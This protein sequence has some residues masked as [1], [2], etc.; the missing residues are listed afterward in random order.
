MGS[1]A[2]SA[3]SLD[4]GRGRD[5]ADPEAPLAGGDPETD[6][7]VGLARPL[8]PRR[9]TGSLVSIQAQLSGGRGVAGLIGDVASRLNSAKAL[10][11]QPCLANARLKHTYPGAVQI[12]P[13]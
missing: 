7:E 1:S 10:E 5:V 6:Q 12:V 9:T 8:S 3:S 13:V 2:A 4:E 11:P